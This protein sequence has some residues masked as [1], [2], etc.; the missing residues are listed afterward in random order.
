MSGIFGPIRS[1]WEHFFMKDCSSELPTISEHFV[2][3]FGLASEVSTLSWIW[4][5]SIQTHVTTFP[6]ITDVRRYFDEIGFRNCTKITTGDDKKIQHM[7]TSIS[8]LH[9]A[10]K[11]RPTKS[12][13]FDDFGVRE[14][15][16]TPKRDRGL[17]F[18]WFQG[19]IWTKGAP[20]SSQGSPRAPSK[21]QLLFEK[22]PK[23]MANTRFL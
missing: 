19:S 3:N 10:P 2:V 18:G 20:G 1:L 16:D 15:Q 5:L 11:W 8:T 7:F 12:Y 22:V 9:M 6:R 4:Y 17:D 13:T 23:W 14:P 21:V